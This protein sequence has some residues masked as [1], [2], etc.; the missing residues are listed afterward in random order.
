M[1][2]DSSTW[3]EATLVYSGNYDY[4]ILIVAKTGTIYISAE[5][6]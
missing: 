6:R 2:D 4:Y 1:L 5:A 3:G